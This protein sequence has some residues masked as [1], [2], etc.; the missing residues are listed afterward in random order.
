M[1]GLIENPAWITTIDFKKSGDLIYILGET[2]AEL[3]GS[4][5]Q[6]N[7]TRTCEGPLFNFDLRYEQEATRIVDSVNSRGTFE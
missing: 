5:L 7:A 6:K 1:V 3:N 2:T 4:E